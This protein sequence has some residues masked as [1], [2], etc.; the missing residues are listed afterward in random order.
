M[1]KKLEKN[2]KMLSKFRNSVTVHNHKKHQEH[3][4]ARENGDVLKNKE[5]CVYIP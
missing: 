3:F 2:I 4:Y 1:L 5:N